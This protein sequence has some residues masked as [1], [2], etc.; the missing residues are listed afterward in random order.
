MSGEAELSQHAHAEASVPAVLVGGDERLAGRAVLGGDNLRASI[1]KLQVLDMSSH[2]HTEM[3]R[4]Q[5]RIGAV[6]HL[7]RIELGFCREAA[8]EQYDE[9][10]IRLQ[11]RV[12]AGNRLECCHQEWVEQIARKK[13]SPFV[14]IT[15]KNNYLCNN[16]RGN[17]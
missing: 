16:K 5:V 2:K 3:E 8:D 12:A 14:G 9:E 11:A 13:V 17:P 1:L 10:K 7:S 6:L 15:K 4:P